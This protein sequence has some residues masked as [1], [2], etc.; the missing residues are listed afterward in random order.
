M[1]SGTI[2]ELN[3]WK[4][5]KK[6]RKPIEIWTEMAFTVTGSH[7]EHISTAFSQVFEWSGLDVGSDIV[8][9]LICYPP[10]VF[11]FVFSDADGLLYRAMHPDK[12]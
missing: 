7:E 4:S 5:E 11:L 10:I 3:K 1:I 9:H 12:L 2:F 8:C 6:L